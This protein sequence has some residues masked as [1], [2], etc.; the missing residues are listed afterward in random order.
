MA[1]RAVAKAAVLEISKKFGHLGEET[2]AK[3]EQFDP[4]IRQEVEQ[5]LLAKDKIAG[6]AIIT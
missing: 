2:L 3:L 5:S 6:H 4:A 1:S